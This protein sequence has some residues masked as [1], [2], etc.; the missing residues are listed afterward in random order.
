M[1]QSKRHSALEA[2]LNT[3]S[4]FVI[5]YL[6]G[7]FIFPLLGWNLD[8]KQNFYA[9][10][11]YTVISIV[12]SYVWRRVFNW[13]HHKELNYERNLE[14]VKIV[15]AEAIR[16]FKNTN[17]ELE[18]KENADKIRKVDNERDGSNSTGNSI[19]LR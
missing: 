13:Y 7:F 10:S 15:T 14:T 5:S 2:S 19:R 11:F 9:V 12:R 18:E 16:L 4:G 1:K 17:R 6:A 8:Y 3:F